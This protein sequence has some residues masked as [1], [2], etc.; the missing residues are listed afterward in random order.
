ME[1]DSRMALAGLVCIAVI[2]AG[3]MIEKYWDCRLTTRLSQNECLFGPVVN[4]P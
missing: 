4:V 2:V 3:I 1:N